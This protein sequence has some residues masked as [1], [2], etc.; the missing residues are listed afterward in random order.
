MNEMSH[1]CKGFN[2][3]LLTTAYLLPSNGT[4]SGAQAMLIWH[5]AI[6]KLKWDTGSD[7]THP[8][9]T[10]RW[11]G[12]SRKL[13]KLLQEATAAACCCKNGPHGTVTESTQVWNSEAQSGKKAATHVHE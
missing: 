7:K 13:K 4:V 12:N 9:H 1:L 2:S 11:H 10:R 8:M 5:D 3:I 6:Q